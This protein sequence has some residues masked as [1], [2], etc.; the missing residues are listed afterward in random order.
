MQSKTSF[1]N[2]TL[3]LKNLRRF[4]PIWGLG[5]FLAL[6]FPIYLLVRGFDGNAFRD[7]DVADIVRLYYDYLRVGAPIVAMGSAMIVAMAVWNYL[8]FHRS[9]SAMHSFP[10]SRTGLFVTN[11]LSGLT[12]MLIPYV[13]GGA[14]T[15]ATVAALGMGVPMATFY[16]IAG[17]IC[18]SVL[19]FSIA[20]FTAQLVGN[21]VAFPVI[22]ML[23]NFLQA[24]IQAALTA[25][26]DGFR[27]GVDY[28]FNTKF[29]F[30]S[31]I[32]Q[33]FKSVKVE[34]DYSHPIHVS[35]PM[36][37]YEYT[38]YLS[39]IKNFYVIVIYGAVG[40][41]IAGAAYLLYAKRK[42]ES[43]GSTVAFSKLKPVVAVIYTIIVG[44][45]GS[46]VLYAIFFFASG[47]YK[48]VPFTICLIVAVVIGCVTGKIFIERSSKIFNKRTAIEVA[49]GIVVAVAFA[50][51]CRYDVFGVEGRIPSKDI[52]DI[53]VYYDGQ[54]YEFR[55]GRD[56]ELMKEFM[57]IHRKLTINV[58]A[59]AE[60]F[61]RPAYNDEHIFYSYLN[62]YYDFNNGSTMARHYRISY[63]M[64][65]N[66]RKYVEEEIGDFFSKKEVCMKSFEVP[67]GY[68]LTE[69]YVSIPHIP[70]EV[71][72]PDSPAYTYDEFGNAFY[73][74]EYGNEYS[75]D[76]T[77]H[78]Y[79]STDALLLYNALKLDILE[80]NYDPI[81]ISHGDGGVI[82]MEFTFE[83]GENDN[84]R[85]DWKNVNI[86][87]E[88]VHSIDAIAKLLH[89]SPEA[90][91]AESFFDAAG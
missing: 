58:A 74:D 72:K 14:A 68:E 47:A 32:M 23:I 57:D 51:I 46:M 63:N 85:R 52:K 61:E 36:D 6:L 39:S 54:E 42:S 91:K 19:F 17:V 11:Y 7:L 15:I 75:Y 73:V 79:F 82:W 71:V 87:R 2:K 8:Y 20:S 33:L 88:M 60:R 10:V 44:A 9:V 64:D 76:P 35:M 70:G 24:I 55:T 4:W 81:R 67:E 31:P 29:L 66:G 27:Y 83:T 30:L 21:I 90:I 50:L 34:S 84:Y 77:E 28:E 22:Y 69:A 26:Y 65:D 37:S 12:L 25:V 48:L 86:D 40:L 78:R 80:G 13:I 18:E 16:L 43:A 56:D 53:R 45:V 62:I 38:T 49:V 3:Y 89:V 1:F 59:V 41:L 5:S